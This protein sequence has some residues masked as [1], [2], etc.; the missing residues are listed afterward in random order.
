M[1]NKE[2]GG[3]QMERIYYLLIRKSHYLADRMYLRSFRRYC[4]VDSS[5]IVEGLQVQIGL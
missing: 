5:H 3:V 1:G 2:R 4:R